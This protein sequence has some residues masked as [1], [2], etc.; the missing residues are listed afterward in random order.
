MKR[1]DLY[2][3]KVK[4]GSR[5]QSGPIDKMAVPKPSATPALRATG[6]LLAGQTANT[7]NM[8]TP[9]IAASQLPDS[10]NI[11][12]DSPSSLANEE[13]K[14]NFEEVKQEE[15]PFPESF[16][17][18]MVAGKWVKVHASGQIFSPRTGHECIYADGKIYLF[19]GT[20]DDER[21]NDLYSYC[22]RSNQWIKIQVEG[23]VP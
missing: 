13:L 20:D 9:M 11:T 3:A 14:M 15:L 1:N 4:S 10:K 12:I 2:V 6:K 8:Q 17:K 19:A 22:I 23:E 7:I 5:Q 18:G 21:L 16:V